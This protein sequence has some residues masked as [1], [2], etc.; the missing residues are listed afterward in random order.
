MADP[1]RSR[2]NRHSRAPAGWEEPV[3]AQVRQQFP[4]PAALERLGL[5]SGGDGARSDDV[6]EKALAGLGDIARWLED[7]GSGK[8][9]GRLSRALAAVERVRQAV[10]ALQAEANSR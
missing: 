7:L 3:P 6:A 2:R 8:P 1:H 5:G 4:D 10:L 9:D